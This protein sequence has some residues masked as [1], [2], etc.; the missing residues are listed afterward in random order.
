MSSTDQRA[1]Y[2]DYWSRTGDQRVHGPVARHTRRLLR[3]ALQG[4]A[5]R[6]VLDVGC[7]EGT[8]LRELFKDRDDLRLAGTDISPLAVSLATTKNPDHEFILLDLG[9]APLKDRFDLVICSEVIE[10]IENDQQALEHLAAMTN[11]YLVVTTLAG[12]MRGHEREIGHLRNY[13]PEKLK[14]MVAKTGLKPV[15]MVQWGWPFFSPLYRDLLELLSSRTRRITTG[16]FNLFRRMICRLLFMVF[17]LNSWRKGEQLVLLAARDVKRPELTLLPEEPAI[18]VIIPVR[19]E[20]VHMEQCIEGLRRLDYP[21]SKLEII[22][23]D[24]G[25][26]DR[27]AAIARSSGFKVVDNPGL[28][29]SSGRN[30]GFAASKGQI[31]V[32]TDADC[33]FDPEWLKKAGRYFREP[34]VGGV[35]GPTRVPED[36]NAFGRAVGIVFEMAGRLNVT[37]H[38]EKVHVASESDDLPGC[39]AFYR[40]EALDTVMPANAALHSNEDVEMNA[41]LRQEGFRLLMT[42]DVEV[43]HYKRSSP[44]R[45]RKQMHAFAIGRLQLGRRDR[46]FL[47]PG[48]WVAG[49]VA[50]AT[51][52]LFLLAGLI[53]WEIWVIG[54]ASI[55]VVSSIVLV[56]FSIRFSV[57]VA[58]NVLLAFEAAATGWMSGFLRE[59]F[60]PVKPAGGK[61]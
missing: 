45:F 58:L 17:F 7:G 53:R 22:F 31:I 5:F 39:N 25:S 8:M 1:F 35:G 56:Y 38:F 46:T 18:S 30:E 29:I 11:R 55:L 16:S 24:G 50:P 20:E 51:A 13:D 36:Q 2:Q 9:Q 28:K 42:P 49:V 47:K 21:A 52:L 57:S 14:T 37:T 10:H 43:Y 3:H 60:F 26:T 59:L 40:R 27:T 15:R 44:G 41:C 54:A 23:A 12:R 33:L 61:Q 4:L 6:S 32:F 19:N 34:D 48:H